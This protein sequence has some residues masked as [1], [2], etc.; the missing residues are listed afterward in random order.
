VT[1]A[2]GASGHGCRPHTA[3]LIIEA[4]GPSRGECLNEA[5]RALAEVGETTATVP[6]PL[7]F[8]AHVA[9]DLL[10]RVLEEAVYVVDA[11]E[12]LPVGICL[13]DRGD[14]GL[15]GHFDTVPLE[16]LDLPGHGSR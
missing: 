6:V 5:V 2:T 4:W 15:A 12:R 7:Q 9:L 8:D 11:V 10:V 3:D 1:P 14:G 13:E 16:G